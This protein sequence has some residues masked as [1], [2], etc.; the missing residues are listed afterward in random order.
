MLTPKAVYQFT[1]STCQA[2]YIG[3]TERR[4]Q[5]R[6]S[7]HFPKWLTYSSDKV[8]RTSVTDHMLDY[9]HA[10]KKTECF[11]IIYKAQNRR[12]LR[13][14][15]A[16]AI[17]IKK[18]GLNVKRDSDLCLK[19]PWSWGWSTPTSCLPVLSSIS[20]SLPYRLPLTLDY[21]TSYISHHTDSLKSLLIAFKL[22]LICVTW[23]YNAMCCWRAASKYN[24]IHTPACVVHNRWLE[25]LT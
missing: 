24:C 1:C 16:V 10:C 11:T 19:L 23:R 8:T 20:F 21:P 5:D 2:R 13:F 12:L 15:E 25:M 9:G 4:L 14:V 17:R 3:M 18:P 7:E 22:I 6:V